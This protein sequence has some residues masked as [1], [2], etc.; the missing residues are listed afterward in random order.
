MFVSGAGAFLVTE[1][2]WQFKIL[3]TFLSEDTQAL[4][5]RPK[6][7]VDWLKSRIGSGQD[8]NTSVLNS[9]MLHVSKMTNSGVHIVLSHATSTS[10]LKETFS[11]SIDRIHFPPLRSMTSSISVLSINARRPAERTCPNAL[12]RY[13][14][15]FQTM[16]ATI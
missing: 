6:A 9:K 1:R 10:L 8:S 14:R 15:L 11:R 5:Y 12:R 13:C 2:E 16:S 7:F 4:S 3:R